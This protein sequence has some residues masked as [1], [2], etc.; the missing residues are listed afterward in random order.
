MD[1][2]WIC[3]VN[4]TD[5]RKSIPNAWNS[6]ASSAAEVLVVKGDLLKQR[7][8]LGGTGECLGERILINSTDTLAWC[9][10]NR[11]LKTGFLFRGIGVADGGLKL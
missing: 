4:R 3:T 9:S 7:L 8:K 11:L 10:P 5:P 2:K 6:P 1:L